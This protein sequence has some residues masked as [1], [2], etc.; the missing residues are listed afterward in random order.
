MNKTSIPGWQRRAVVVITIS[1]LFSCQFESPITRRCNT[2][3]DESSSA[4]T[5]LQCGA[6]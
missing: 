2:G 4:R 6:F 1:L 5:D 3:D